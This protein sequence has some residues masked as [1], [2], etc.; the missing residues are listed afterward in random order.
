M[1]RQLHTFRTLLEALDALGKA[2]RS[3][4]ALLYSACSAFVAMVAE[5]LKANVEIRVDGLVI[6]RAHGQRLAYPHGEGSSDARSRVAA[7]PR[8]ARDADEVGRGPKTKSSTAG[9]TNAAVLI[10]ETPIAREK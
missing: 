1:I 2:K 4:D 3:T 10:G 5:M 9:R 7:S 8:M 6:A